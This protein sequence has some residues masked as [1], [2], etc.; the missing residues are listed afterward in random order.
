MDRYSLPYKTSEVLLEGVVEGLGKIMMAKAPLFEAIG[1]LERAGASSMISLRDLAYA[2]MKSAKEDSLCDT[3]GFVVEGAVYLPNNP[4]LLVRE[5]PLLDP[6]KKAEAEKI[7]MEDILSDDVAR[8]LE[9]LHIFGL[10]EFY[11]V[12]KGVAEEDLH[13]EP[14]ERRVYLLSREGNEFELNIPTNRLAEEGLTLWAFRDVAKDYGLFS[15]E[16]RVTE[17]NVR[18]L[19]REF[20]MVPAISEDYDDMFKFWVHREL[21]KREDTFMKGEPTKIVPPGSLPDNFYYNQYLKSIS[22]ARQLYH[23]ALLD[24]ADIDCTYKDIQYPQMVRGIVK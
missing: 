3:G 12:H 23:G 11:D 17:M 10:E 4:L 2:R 16:N 20:I 22:F 8:R 21:K 1:Q 19:Y 7:K 15:N 18:F 9:N 13:K 14:Q 5:S 6:A 24:R